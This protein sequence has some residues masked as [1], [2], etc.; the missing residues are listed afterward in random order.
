MSEVRGS[1]W[2]ELPAFEPGAV[3]ERSYPTSEVR[4]SGW[5]EQPHVQGAKTVAAWAQEGL[6]EISH[7]E[8]QE[9]QQ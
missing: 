9:G 2:E 4:G 3:A 8:S 6:E 7:I 1:G 5:E